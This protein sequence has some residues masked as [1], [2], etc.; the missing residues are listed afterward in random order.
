MFARISLPSI[1]SLFLSF[2]VIALP[3]CSARIQVLP[4]PVVEQ[5]VLR[6]GPLCPTSWFCSQGKP[7]SLN[8]KGILNNKTGDKPLFIE[9]Y[10]S[11]FEESFP[12]GISIKLDQTW[13]NLR[14]TST[15]FGDTVRVVS[16]LPADLT[17][18]VLNAK[19]I[20]LSFSSRDNTTTFALSASNADGLK[21]LL[22]DLKEKLDAQSK[23]MITNH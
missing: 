12:I 7:G 1:A 13:H 21:S 5:T 10:M 16:I 17:D 22:K 19:E 8:F 15:D 18:K 6:S 23:L 9:Y 11:S 4:E 20:Q 14:K 2:L 3:G